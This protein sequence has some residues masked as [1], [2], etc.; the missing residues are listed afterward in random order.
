MSERYFEVKGTRIWLAEPVD[1]TGLLRGEVVGREREI[2]MILTAWTVCRN[3]AAR[4]RQAPLLLGEAGVGKNTIVY[5]TARLTGRE[6]YILNGHETVQ[7]CDLLLTPLPPQR[8]RAERFEFK[9]SALLTAMYCGGIAFIDEIGKLRP[10]AL[11][12]L[13]SLL[14][15]R[16]YIDDNTLLLQHFHARSGFRLIAA[17]NCED[18]WTER[19]G[20]YLRGRLQPEIHVAP[21]NADHVETIIAQHR[22]ADGRNQ[23]DLVRR[24]WKNW[25]KLSPRTLPVPRDVISILE[26]A[27]RLAA[28]ERLATEGNHYGLELDDGVDIECTHLD[29]AFQGFQSERESTEE[30]QTDAYLEELY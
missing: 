6:L 11:A 2:E 17:T 12:P 3:R 15:G 24:W 8:E 30:V 21:L 4:E 7:S 19:F 5:E 29:A 23:R 16:R 1:P 28:R 9:A 14:D 27:E 22:E 20:A 18:M 25:R 26:L 10:A 13:S